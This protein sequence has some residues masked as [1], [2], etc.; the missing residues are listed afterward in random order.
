VKTVQVEAITEDGTRRLIARAMVATSYWSR[1]WG[2][3]A[4]RRPEDDTGLLIDPCTGVHTMFMRFS[5][6]VV[7]LDREDRITKV[8]Q[9]LRPFRASMGKG[10]KKALEMPAGAATRAGLKAGDRLAFVP[11][12]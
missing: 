4:K 2:L 3:M 6:D 8:V 9:D 5:L 12:D 10:G 11:V 1:F 7:F